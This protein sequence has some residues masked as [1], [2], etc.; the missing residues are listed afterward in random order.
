MK[1]VI[2]NKTLN[3]LLNFV[4][5]SILMKKIFFLL[6]LYCFS[7]SVKATHIVG[8]EFQLYWKQ[9]YD[10]ALE[11]NFYYDELSTIRYQSTE[12]LDEDLTIEVAIYEKNT[13]QLKQLV[14]LK[15]ISDGFIG[16]KYVE[17]TDYNSTL[18]ETR[19][20]KYVVDNNSETVQLLPTQYN[21]SNGYYIVWERCCR[22][23]DI[24]N[25]LGDDQGNVGQVF[26]MEFPALSAPID[27]G[28]E[29]NSEPIFPIITGD[30][31]CIGRPF[32]FNFSGVDPNGDSLVYSMVTPL[33]GH[34]TPNGAGAGAEPIPP[35][36]AP[37]SQITWAYLNGSNGPRYSA[38]DAIPGNP[39]LSINAHTGILSLTAGV[40]N[41]FTNVNGAQEA[42][43]AFGVLVEEFRKGKKIGEV[44]RDFQFWTVDCPVNPGPAITML[45]PGITPGTTMTYNE[46]DTIKVQMEPKDTCF[47]TL[48]SDTSTAILYPLA[49]TPMAQSIHITNITPNTPAGLLQFPAIVNLPTT[50]TKEP[51]AKTSSICFNPCYTLN[52]DKDT[53]I[54]FTL[55]AADQSCPEPKTD[56]LRV[57]V[58]FIPPIVPKPNITVGPITVNNVVV[59]ND[60]IPILKPAQTI[61]F[62]VTGTVNGYTLTLTGNGRGFSF[63]EYGMIFNTA[64]G[65]DFVTSPYSWKVACNAVGKS[66]FVL[67]FIASDKNCGLNRADTSLITLKVED[68][69][70]DLGKLEPYNVITPNGDFYNDSLELAHKKGEPPPPDNCTYYFKSITIYNRWGAEVYLNT[71]RNFAWSPS[72]PEIPDGVYYFLIDFNAIKQ[73]GWVEVIR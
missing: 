47:P 42:L 61:D 3:K 62:P 8:G 63:S 49:H 10:Y 20:L 58:L 4:F 5:S 27:G 39:P 34:A 73:K 43:Y 67:Q 30:F 9:G 40:P 14:N 38:T 41:S 48:V 45:V 11:M 50:E 22:N 15:R 24:I 55:V 28:Y 36:P 32:T 53:V 16:Y 26:Y 65:F 56:T 68:I 66:P 52:I 46:I 33:Q 1:W 7:L 2:N 17:C 37:Y 23:L 29:F 44:R 6:L 12:L 69:S 57:K 70:T 13:N 18:V 21:S 54:D 25:I 19:L 64:T 51:V 72:K 59:A 31:P 71:D 60:S 35:F